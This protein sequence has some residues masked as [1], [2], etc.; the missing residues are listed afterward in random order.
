MLLPA[1]ERAEDA[2]RGPPQTHRRKHSH[3]AKRRWAEVRGQG[4]G[5]W[6]VARTDYVVPS[7]FSMK[8]LLARVRR[9]LRPARSADGERGS[10][11]SRRGASARAGSTRCGRGLAPPRAPR[12]GSS[13]LS[14]R[15]PGQVL[16]RAR[17]L[18]ELEQSRTNIFE[19]YI[20]SLRNKLHH[21]GSEAHRSEAVPAAPAAACSTPV[22]QQLGAATA[23]ARAGSSGPPWHQVPGR[24]GLCAPRERRERSSRPASTASFRS[25]DSELQPAGGPVSSA[26]ASSRASLEQQRPPVAHLAALP[27]PLAHLHDQSGDEH[28]VTD[29][30]RRDRAS[31]GTPAR[32]R[33]AEQEFGERGL[34]GAA[35]AGLATVT[36]E[37][38]SACTSHRPDQGRKPTAANVRSPIH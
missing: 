37:E 5:A 16:S 6:I 18:N 3:P 38:P 17:I 33:R 11:T 24:E 1:R 35:G 30:R 20:G 13:R 28:G 27:D 36:S 34:L 15:H 10:G 7:P 21:D 31:R 8:K 29:K 9:G 14:H 23:Q 19:V 32:R 22:I 26:H 25:S 4:A 2:R 12:S